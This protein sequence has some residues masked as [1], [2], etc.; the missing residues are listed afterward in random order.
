MI[1]WNS[2]KKETFPYTEALKTDS[3]LERE[4]QRFGEAE[5][6]DMQC[7]FSYNL[8]MGLGFQGTVVKNEPGCNRVMHWTHRE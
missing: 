3:Q 6:E 2:L 1:V 4:S 5:E 8:Y 7:E